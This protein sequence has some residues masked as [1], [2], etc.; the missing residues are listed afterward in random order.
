MSE[1]NQIALFFLRL[2]NNSLMSIKIAFESDWS[3]FHHVHHV[4]R[5]HAPESHQVPQHPQQIQQAL[6]FLLLFNLYIC[7]KS[8]V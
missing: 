8:F 2:T 4:A 1:S 5:R 7:N 3:L 6:R